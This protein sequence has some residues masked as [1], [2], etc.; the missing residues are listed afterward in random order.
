MAFDISRAVP[1]SGVVGS[2]GF[3]IS[4]AKPVGSF[5]LSNAKPVVSEYQDR[6]DYLQ[7]KERTDWDSMTRDEMRELMEFRKSGQAPQVNPATPQELGTI[8][9]QNM[10][11]GKQL[12]A[13]IGKGF[14]D[15]A[16]G[17]SQWVGATPQSDID[18]S[19]AMDRGLTD[20]GAGATGNV[21]GS[22]AAFAPAAFIPGVNS[23]A[24]AAAIGS[25]MGALQPVE[26]GGSRTKNAVIGA[27][28]GAAG[29]GIG[30]GIGKTVSAA[31][32]KMANIE[33]KIV[34]RAARDAASETA[35]AKS[36]AGQAAQDAYRQLEH[37]RELKAAN[38]LNHEGIRLKRELEKELAE[39]AAEK[40]PQSA[41]RKEATSIAYKEA[42]DSE[43]QRASV[44]ADQ[45]LGGT[46]AKQQLVARIKR[47][48][49]GVAGAVIGNMMAPGFGG[50]AGAAV[51]LATRPM[52]HSIRRLAQN[53]SVQ[54]RL[55]S[56]IANPG[57]VSRALTDP[58]ALSLAFPAMRLDESDAGRPE[59][60]RLF[61][62]D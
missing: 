43:A 62:G 9:A 41:A 4:K 16:N 38:L 27:A 56:H 24:G 26:T 5:N 50:A 57:T 11:V 54:Y 22:A 8:A 2:S 1:V 39:K 37:L 59:I 32:N 21:V 18:E 33:A 31:S 3:D 44:R 25:V 23:A 52:L 19:I 14:M 55:L 30:A 35:S 10:S 53:P 28:L 6:I 12:G 60:L 36:A 7:K 61:S 51:G 29:H 20:T 48:W 15:I 58:R 49:P 40:L 13:G 42:I 34:E 47:Y 46:E 17:V 45:L